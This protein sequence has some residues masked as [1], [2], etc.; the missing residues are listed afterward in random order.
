MAMTCSPRMR[1]A[2]SFGEIAG[3][4]LRN[5]RIIGRSIFDNRFCVTEE[6]RVCSPRRMIRNF[7]Q[8]TR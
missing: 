4:I 7:I 8:R 1:L 3:Q 5:Y 6:R 2:G